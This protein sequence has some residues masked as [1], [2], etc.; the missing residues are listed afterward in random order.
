MKKLLMMFFCLSLPVSVV[1]SQET[2]SLLIADFE[3]QADGLAGWTSSI[4]AAY[5]E[6]HWAEDPSDESVGVLECVLDC[7]NGEKG[8]FAKDVFSIVQNGDTAS[9]LVINVYIPG[10][11][12]TGGGSGVQIFAQDRA[13]WNWQNTWYDGSALLLEE[14]NRLFFDFDYRFETIENYTISAGFFAG[15]EFIP[16]TG[17]SW[18]GS[19]YADNFYLLGVKGTSTPVNSAASEQPSRFV[20][21]Q[22]YPNPFNPETTIF[23]TLP[24]NTDVTLGV[25]DMNGKLVKT[26]IDHRP[27]QAGRHAVPVDGSELSSGVYIYCLQTP[28]TVSAKKMLLV[29]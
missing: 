13:T 22:N 21:E 5:V 17:S 2:D 11:F 1:L 9:G 23:Y 27:Q 10:D 4:D 16:A 12:P 29:K 8:G 25:Y 15:V 3:N 18:S 20:L 26:L 19:V 7:S 24:I 14:W 6:S 28:G